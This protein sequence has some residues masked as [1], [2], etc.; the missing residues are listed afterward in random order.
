MGVGR[1]GRTRA[2]RDSV[3][4]DADAYRRVEK[5]EQATPPTTSVRHNAVALVLVAINAVVYVVGW[6]R[7][8]WG[9]STP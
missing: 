7:T 3:E 8:S 2:R 5:P 6:I 4:R 1:L 9:R